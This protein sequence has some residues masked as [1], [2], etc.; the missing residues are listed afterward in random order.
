MA[1]IEDNGRY[2]LFKK[3]LIIILRNFC[4]LGLNVQF[5]GIIQGF[6]GAIAPIASLVCSENPFGRDLAQKIAT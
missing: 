5:S 4:L 2:F 3:L 1:P 6:S